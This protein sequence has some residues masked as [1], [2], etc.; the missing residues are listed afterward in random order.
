MKVLRKLLLRLW[1][2]VFATKP[3]KRIPL[4]PIYRFYWKNGNRPDGK[5]PHWGYYRGGDPSD[6]NERDWI[7][8]AVR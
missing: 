6:P 8:E 5:M 3:K 2:L 7:I 1:F 4:R